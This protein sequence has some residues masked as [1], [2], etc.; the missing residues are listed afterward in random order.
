M[1]IQ[2]DLSEPAVSFLIRVGQGTVA[3]FQGA[4]AGRISETYPKPR[5]P[6]WRRLHIPEFVPLVRAACAAMT[7]PGGA[8]SDFEIRCLCLSVFSCTVPRLKGLRKSCSGN[9]DGPYDALRGECTTSPNGLFRAL[10]P[11]R[12]IDFR[13]IN[14]TFARSFFESE[15]ILYSN[16]SSHRPKVVSS[17]MRHICFLNTRGSFYN[18]TLRQGE[19]SAFISSSV[20]LNR[21]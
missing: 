10:M 19:P 9:H 20:S 14:L 12:S 11:N 16:L 4:F 8:L 2:K 18:R 13:L 6:F 17:L 7:E 1:I 3:A 15:S 21:L 5:R